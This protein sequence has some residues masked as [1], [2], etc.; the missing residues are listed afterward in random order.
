MSKEVDSMVEDVRNVGNDRRNYWQQM[1][2]IVSF[3]HPNQRTGAWKVLEVQKTPEGR[4]LFTMRQGV[5]GKK[6]SQ[7]QIIM[8]MTEQEIAL[9][10]LKLM[11]LI[12]G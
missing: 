5:S 9:L 12:Q 11:K 1:E 2:T 8:Q 10:A 6:G 7:Q 4:V 3:F